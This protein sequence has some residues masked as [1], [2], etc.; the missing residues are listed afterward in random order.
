[1]WV[2]PE[3]VCVHKCRRIWQKREEVK[4]V[5]MVVG[6]PRVTYGGVR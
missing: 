5:E 2:W 1:M 4:L 6:L 3:G